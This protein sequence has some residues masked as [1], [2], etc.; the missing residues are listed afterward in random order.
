M[1]GSAFLFFYFENWILRL[2]N[3][4]REGIGDVFFWILAILESVF[5]FRFALYDIPA[6]MG[7]GKLRNIYSD[8]AGKFKR[9]I[10]AFLIGFS[11]GL[12][13]Y[14]IEKLLFL[15]GYIILGI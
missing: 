14:G 1:C 13:F 4:R 8:S 2:F 12:A 9:Y 7:I 5:G 11:L 6:K 3:F 10:I 15:V